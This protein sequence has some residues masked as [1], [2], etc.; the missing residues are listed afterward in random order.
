MAHFKAGTLISVCGLLLAAPSLVRA[1]AANRELEGIRKKIESEKK[2]LSQLQVKEGSVLEALGKIQS[3]LD[4]RSKELMLANARL[5]TIAHQLAAKEAEARSLSQSIASRREILSKRAAALYR[6]HKSGSPLIV[7]N[8]ALSFSGFY[9]R[10]KY[11]T[12]AMVFDQTMLTKLQEESQNQEI[13][14]EELAQKK[15]ELNEQRQALATAK[16]GVRREAEKKKVLLASLRREK[17]TRLRALKEME[18]AAQRLEKMMEEISRRAMNKPREGLLPRSPGAGLEALRGKLDWPVHGQVSAPFGKYQHPEFAAE[19]VRKGID[20]DAPIGEEVRAVEKGTVVYADRFSG[21]GKMVIVDHG[22]RYYTI[23]GHLSEIVKK[24]GDVV[25]RGEVL[26]QAGD[27]DSLAG[28]KLYFE[29]RKDGRSLD[30]VPWL[31]KQ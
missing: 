6:W 10:Q 30:P 7:L 26:G 14:R 21:Y 22:E 1:A 20:I 2:G 8:G 4:K 17:S 27:S 18:A 31:K 5:S 24:A 15:Q 3:D 16:E 23:Y 11:L 9:Q 19:I 29:M 12:M 25:K 28:A 13:V